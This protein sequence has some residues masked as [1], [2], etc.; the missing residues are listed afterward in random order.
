[1][2]INGGGDISV[3]QQREWLHGSEVVQG[4][5]WSV[6]WSCCPIGLKSRPLESAGND[7]L[8]GTRIFTIGVGLRDLGRSL[9]NL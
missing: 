8:F 3:A 1:M 2:L 4:L 7:E 6:D 5:N 9:R